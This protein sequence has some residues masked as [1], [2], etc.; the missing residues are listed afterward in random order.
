MQFTKFYYG[1]QEVPLEPFIPLTKE[2]EVEVAHAFSTNRYVLKIW[3]Y[4]IQKGSSCT[5]SYSWPAST[6]KRSWFPMRNLAL[7][8]REK[9]FNALDRVHG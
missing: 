7:R 4:V 9:S 8:S 3:L 2:E 5:I 6:G 1:F